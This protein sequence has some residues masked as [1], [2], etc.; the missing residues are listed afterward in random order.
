MRQFGVIFGLLLLLVTPAA[1]LAQ[2]HEAKQP[3]FNA[4]KH[5]M[6]YPGPGREEPEPANLHEVLIGYFGPSDPA[7]PEG[8]DL[9]RAVSLA[10]EEA[11]AEGGY[12]GLPFRAVPAW[13]ENPWGTGVG[14][15]AR[16]VYYDKVWAIIGGID[17]PSTHLAEQIVAKARL[18]LI[19]PASTDKTVNLAGVP[20]MFSALPGDHVAAP[21]IGEALLTY[22][23]PFGILAATD[24]DSHM[25]LVE[26]KKFLATRGTGPV[27]E[28][29]FASGT[30][31]FLELAE[32]VVDSRAGA[33][34]LIAGAGDS[35][36]LLTKLRE[37]GFAGRVLGGPWMAR[38]VFLATA[39]VA[40]EGVLLPLLDDPTS[41]FQR[42]AEAFRARFG[43]FPDF[44]VA[45]TY[46]ATRLLVAAIRKA[47]LNRVRIL[48]AVRELSPWEGVAGRMAWDPVGESVRPVRLGKIEHGQIVLAG[49]PALQNCPNS[50][51]PA[52]AIPSQAR[53]KNPAGKV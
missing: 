17:G 3:Y 29:E 41:E 7:H 9:W 6:E 51:E 49:K 26:L 33:V 10:I 42:F 37:K 18:V 32:R 14:S 16:L 27:F 13:S 8:G 36:R 35:G 11:N 1:G 34:A 19:S 24:H 46:D 52:M 40:A 28:Y 23:E 30:R 48:D 12:R 53:Q 5:Q 4:R 50:G 44:A 31:S 22:P 45:Q 21:V 15:L 20:W 2:Q 43:V 39:G 25:F 38:R 47:G